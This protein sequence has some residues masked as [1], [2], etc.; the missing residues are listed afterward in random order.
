MLWRS[1]NQLGHLTNVRMR[2]V[3]AVEDFSLEQPRAEETLRATARQQAA[4]AHLSQQALAGAL[5]PALMDEAVAIVARVCQWRVFRSR[6]FPGSCLRQS[7]ALFRVLAQMGYPVTIHFGV[8]THG[9]AFLGHSWVTLNGRALAE[10]WSPRTYATVYSY[11]LSV[12][13]G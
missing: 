10:P 4:V 1:L 8:Q 9:P 12:G 6:P 5:V 11:P 3:R 7:L 2:L 13:R